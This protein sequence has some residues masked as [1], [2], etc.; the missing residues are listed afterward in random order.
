MLGTA[1]LTGAGSIRVA[2]DVPAHALGAPEAK[3]GAHDYQVPTLVAG[4]RSSAQARV[5]SRRS[6]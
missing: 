4:C 5:R 2:L 6:R 3:L 1:C